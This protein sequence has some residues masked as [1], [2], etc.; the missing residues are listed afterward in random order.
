MQENEHRSGVGTGTRDLMRTKALE[1]SADIVAREGLKALTIRRVAQAI[2]CSIGTIYNLFQDLDQLLVRLNIATL[3][4]LETTLVAALARDD[5][6]D[7]PRA[8]L[9]ALARA[10]VR[11]TERNHARWAA[12]IEAGAVALDE[13]REVVSGIIDR[14]VGLIEVDVAAHLGAGA[15]PADCRRIAAALW[16]GIEGI[17]RLSVTDNLSMVTRDADA[18]GLSAD[19]V[20]LVL[21]GTGALRRR[22]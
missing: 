2:G 18:Y 19:Q 8:R 15:D 17:G 12:V 16:V 11:F 13:D 10:Y 9:Q 4:E 21:G 20:D 7:T 22:P 1:A 14:L 3:E 5:A 6:G